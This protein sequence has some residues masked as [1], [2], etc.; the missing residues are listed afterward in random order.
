MALYTFLT[1]LFA[2]ASTV[3]AFPQ[4]LAITGNWFFAHDPSLVQRASDGKYFL[5]STHNGGQIITATNLA[6]YVSSS[7][8][9]IKNDA[10]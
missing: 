2:F 4:P 7:Q 8:V 6:G 5:F 1:L 3:I 10:T 9:R